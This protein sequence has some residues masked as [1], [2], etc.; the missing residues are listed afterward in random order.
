MTTFV[1]YLT[2][3]YVI[4]AYCYMS[5]ERPKTKEPTALEVCNAVLLLV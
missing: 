5:R 3:H 1:R 2:G 4:I